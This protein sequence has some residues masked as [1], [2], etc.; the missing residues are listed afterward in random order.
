M[1]VW[2]EHHNQERP[3]RGYRN[4][5]KRPYDTILEF[6]GRQDSDLRNPN[7]KSAGKG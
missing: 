3:H 5:G 6:A 1:D 4:Q 7:E 2:L